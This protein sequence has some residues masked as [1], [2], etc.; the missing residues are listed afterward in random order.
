[1]NIYLPL[2]FRRYLARNFP[3]WFHS[4]YSTIDNPIEVPVQVAAY[5]LVIDH[6]LQPDDKVLDVGFGLGYGL[7]MMSDK[8]VELSGID[9]DQA[10]VKMAKQLLKGGSKIREVIHY[11]GMHI[12]YEDKSFDVVTCIDVIEHVPVYQDFLNELIRVTKRV[13]VISTPNRRIENTR[14]DGKPKNY[15]HIREWS[16]EEFTDIVGQYKLQSCDWNYINGPW[17]GPFTYSNEPGKDT[18]AMT[19]ALHVF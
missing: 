11:D 2:R 7:K 4:L 18:Q 12:P 6:Y 15:W 9:I 1:M 10:A 19:P 5:K 13:L 3:H 16:P 8:A 17:E 14:P